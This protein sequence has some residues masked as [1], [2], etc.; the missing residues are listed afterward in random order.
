ML[1]AVDGRPWAGATVLVKEALT[2]A[3]VT[4]D[5]QGRFA[6][7]QMASGPTSLM[8]LGARDEFPFSFDLTLTPGQGL[9]LGTIRATAL[10]RRHPAPT[11]TASASADLGLQ[12]FVA[13][14]PPS[15]PT[16]AAVV[17][18][19]ALASRGQAEPNARLWIVA[20]DPA[21]PA[22]R[23]G[24]RVGDAIRAVGLMTI[25]DGSDA[26]SAMSS[27]SEAWR[28]KGRAVEWVVQRG[29]REL[30]I[31]VVVPR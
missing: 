20:V 15:G 24:L 31:P 25:D 16:L 27:L 7:D 17:S 8:F 1:L 12:F 14:A 5:D 28:S 4:T 2:H 30:R 26:A 29:G 23:A 19:P 21:G 9:D 13:A 6:I 11:T 22:A 18:D 3:L 10:G